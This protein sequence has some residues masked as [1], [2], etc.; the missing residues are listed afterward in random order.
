MSVTKK[1]DMTVKS[2]MSVI[3]DNIKNGLILANCS[4]ANFAKNLSVSPGSVSGWLRG[5]TEP[6]LHML[7]RIASALGVTVADLVTPDGVGRAPDGVI[8][9]PVISARAPYAVIG[10]MPAPREYSAYHGLVAVCGASDLWLCVPADSTGL[11]LHC[12]L[13]DERAG[14]ELRPGYAFRGAGGWSCES[15][16]YGRPLY[17]AD[18]AYAVVGRMAPVSPSAYR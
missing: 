17:G 15:D 8:V 9:C 1:A 4:Q 16:A 5:T 18:I 10:Q 11:G 13:R 3:S 2:A 6:P 7:D 12:V 14:G